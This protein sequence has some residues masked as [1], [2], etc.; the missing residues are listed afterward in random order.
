MTIYDETG[1]RYPKHWRET[2]EVCADGGH[3]AKVGEYEQ[4]IIEKVIK[5]VRSAKLRTRIMD[6]HHLNLIKVMMD[7]TET[8]DIDEWQEYLTEYL[9][10]INSNLQGDS[11]AV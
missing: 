6:I 5:E 4:F 10:E 3:G 2:F 9:N 1:F 11:Y 8:T 7:I